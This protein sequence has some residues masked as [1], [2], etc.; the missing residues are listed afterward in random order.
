MASSPPHQSN[1]VNCSPG[2][3]YFLPVLSNSE[4]YI[5]GITQCV[6][7]YLIP[8][9]QHCICELYS[10]VSSSVLMYTFCCWIAFTCFWDLLVPRSLCTP[11]FF[12]YNQTSFW[13][14]FFNSTECCRL[15]H[16]TSDETPLLIIM[17]PFTEQ[18]LSVEPWDVETAKY[19][20]FV[21]HFLSPLCS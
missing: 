18:I 15:T 16:S 4:H 5:D 10:Q 21:L 2:V 13:D 17:P 11:F 3:S 1:K 19:K 6:L 14:F 9:P 12:F 7:F 8:F 20:F